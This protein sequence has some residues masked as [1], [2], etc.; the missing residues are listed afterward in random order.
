M[1]VWMHRGVPSLA[2]RGLWLSALAALIEVAKRDDLHAVA[3]PTPE[4]LGSLPR[5][6][7]LT[8][9]MLEREAGVRVLVV[10]PVS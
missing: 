5:V 7:Q 6:Q 1:C 3:V 8:R 10:D 2:G 4:D 9:Q